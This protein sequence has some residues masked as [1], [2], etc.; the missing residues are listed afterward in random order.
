MPELREKPWKFDREVVPNPRHAFLKE[1]RY[2]LTDKDGED[3]VFKISKELE[4]R[5]RW[6]EQLPEKKKAWQNKLS[7]CFQ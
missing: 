1:L 4:E 7:E 5:V 6:W 2:L 3:S